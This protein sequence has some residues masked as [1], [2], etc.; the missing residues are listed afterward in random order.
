MFVSLIWVSLSDRAKQKLQI[1]E[2]QMT[3]RWAPTKVVA[4]PRTLKFFYRETNVQRI[5]RNWSSPGPTPRL[6]VIRVYLPPRRWTAKD[7]HLRNPLSPPLEAAPDTGRRENAGKKSMVPLPYW[8]PQIKTPTHF[9][10]GNKQSLG[11][12]S[13]LWSLCLAK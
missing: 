8:K 2:V 6:P 1:V 12:W 3:S 9:L 13:L 11:H 10:I 4:N 5:S 7:T